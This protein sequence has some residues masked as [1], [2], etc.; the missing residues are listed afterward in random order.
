[1]LASIHLI[2]ETQKNSK[3]KE[4]NTGEN[5][6]ADTSKVDR[7]QLM[8]LKTELSLTIKSLVLVFVEV[9]PRL[10]VSTVMPL[11]G[12]MRKHRMEYLPSRRNL[13]V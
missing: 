4:E 5:V 2:S 8:E 9:V 11:T 13:R 1:M 12:I 3:T 7:G 10:M 6:A